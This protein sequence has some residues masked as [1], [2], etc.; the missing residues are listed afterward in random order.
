MKNKEAVLG[1]LEKKR[2]SGL[3]ELQLET[4]LV[5]PVCCRM[6]CPGV[7]SS[8]RGTPSTMPRNSSSGCWIEFTRISTI[9]LTQTSGLLGRYT[10]TARHWIHTAVHQ[11][12]GAQKSSRFV[13][14][15]STFFFLI[16]L[17]MCQQILQTS[18]MAA[19]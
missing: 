4:S 8:S 10:A 16:A 19:I 1:A 3:G 9:S 17:K 2:N 12:S 18:L 15:E 6:W 5:C 7:L 13:L 11:L 14:R